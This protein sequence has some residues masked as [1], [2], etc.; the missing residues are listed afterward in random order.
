VLGMA[1]SKNDLVRRHV[2]RIH[3]DR[4]LEYANTVTGSD[5]LGLLARLR[6]KG[7]V[8]DWGKVE[9]AINE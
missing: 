9:G 8:I 4:Y 5:E 1:T 6:G 2:A 3:I 7:Y